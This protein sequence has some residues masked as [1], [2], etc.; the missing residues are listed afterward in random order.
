MSNRLLG[1]LLA[2][3]VALG[4][5]GMFLVNGKAIQTTFLAIAVVLAAVTWVAYR[6]SQRSGWRA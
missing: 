1:V 3:I 6:K 4:L 5:V 2:I